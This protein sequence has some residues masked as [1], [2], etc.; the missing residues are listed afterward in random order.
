MLRPGSIIKLIPQ[1]KQYNI[2][3]GDQMVRG[4]NN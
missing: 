1:I 4:S 3:T 2:H